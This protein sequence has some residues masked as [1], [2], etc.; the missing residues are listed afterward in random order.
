VKLASFAAKGKERLGLQVD[1]LLVDLATFE[2][3]LPHPQPL[4]R[5]MLDL[6]E[7]GPAGLEWLRHAA[8][9]AGAD[10]ADVV[11]FRLDEDNTRNLTHKTPELL[12]FLT[13]FMTLLPGDIV[14]LGTALQKSTGGGAVQN[15]DLNRLGG[16]ISV[17]IER[18]GSLTNGVKWVG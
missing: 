6:I 4:P 1:G 5:T 18:I 8:Q 11:R 14:S 16:P 13:R 17:T 9:I 15:I 3:G 12:A 10:G 2:A 7:A